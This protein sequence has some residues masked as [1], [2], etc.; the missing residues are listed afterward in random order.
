MHRRRAPDRQSRPGLVLAIGRTIRNRTIALRPSIGGVA[1]MIGR[2][3]RNSSARSR[4]G[5][6]KPAP[7]KIVLH[8]RATR[9]SPVCEVDAG[10][11]SCAGRDCL[12][13]YRP[14][15]AD[16]MK[17]GPWDAHAFRGPRW[18]ARLRAGVVSRVDPINGV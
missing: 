16:A 2:E 4:R 5:C 3:L 7:E 12:A 11:D 14:R 1:H 17:N 9:L 8:V 15:R 18:R 13:A 10:E 6:E